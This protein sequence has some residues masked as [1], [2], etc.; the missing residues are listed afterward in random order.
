MISKAHALDNVAFF[1][2]NSE[3]GYSEMVQKIIDSKPFGN[4]KFYIF[5]FVKRV[6]DASG[7]KVM[8]HQPR[9]TKPEP[10]PGT[11]LLR[12][13]PENPGQV[14]ILWT[15]PNRENF[16]MYKQGRMFSDPFVYECVKKFLENPQSLIEDEPDDL[17]EEK[18]RDIYRG[19]KESKKS[20][21]G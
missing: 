5:Q 11:T 14:T 3:K 1:K 19:I 15:L 13:D 10:L 20:G 2:E 18:I 16:N 4:V 9:L 6:D 8:H 17:P 7:V 12:C 21:S